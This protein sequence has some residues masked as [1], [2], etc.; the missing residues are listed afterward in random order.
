MIVHALNDLRQ[1]LLSTRGVTAEVQ[2]AAQ[3][4][5]RLRAGALHALQCVRL[6]GALDEVESRLDGF[7]EHRV[8]LWILIEAQNE[9]RL[10]VHDE[11]VLAIHEWTGTR[12]QRN[13]GM[14]EQAGE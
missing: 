8:I 6:R 13:G 2:R 1:P 9:T 14:A 12:Q 4:D 10:T 7:L 5:P 3:V 11:E